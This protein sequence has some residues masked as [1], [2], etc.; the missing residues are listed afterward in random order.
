MVSRFRLDLNKLDDRLQSQVVIHGEGLAYLDIDSH[1]RGDKPAYFVV[2][3]F[4]GE[5]GHG[6]P[7]AL[8]MHSLGFSNALIVYKNANIS[9]WPQQAGDV[10][11]KTHSF[12]DKCD[13]IYH[14]GKFE[15]GD[16]EKFKRYGVTILGD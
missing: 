15:L 10:Y 7:P 14:R 3:D 1:F 13:A 5:G 16:A 11:F 6:I 8:V 2:L 9:F 12:I 4:F